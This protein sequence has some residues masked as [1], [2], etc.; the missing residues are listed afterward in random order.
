MKTVWIAC[1]L[2]VLLAACMPRQS[3]AVAGAAKPADVH[4][5]QNSL[6]W[7]GTYEG[8]LPCA[9]CP[10]V[11]TRL[12]LH[13]DGS[14]ELA[15]RALGRDEA[16]QTVLGQF[17]WNAAG[18][19]VT[20]DAKG[21]GQQVSV[22]EGRLVLLDR[23]GPPAATPSAKRVLTL[24][25]PATAAAGLAQALEAH[26]WSLEAAT[27][28]QG[29]PIAAVSPAPGRQFVFN[30]AGGRLHVE[31]GCN[32]LSGGYRIDAAG[33]MTVGRMAATMMA[34]EPLKMQ[35]D[36]ALSDLLAGPL[37]VE[38]VQGAE[39]R[40]RLTSTAKDVLILSGELTPEARYGAPSIVFLEVAARK[41]ACNNP[42]NGEALCLQ[43]RERRYDGQGLVVGAPGPW[44][45]LYEGINGFTHTPGE[46]TVLRLKQFQRS[47]ATAGAP[48]VIYVLDLKIESEIVPR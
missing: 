16:A 37:K 31:G 1:A 5:S 30:F 26:R 2:V 15:T 27:D 40:L 46:R 7:A 44:R 3:Q 6:D 13:R 42:L 39:P 23:D 43:V 38:L 33:Q 35:A 36:A 21:G 25:A 8:I 14:Y 10:G 28:G 17:A 32:Q 48:S 12:T 9:D 22:G 34:C 19:G 11:E 47:P 41:V 29:R 24:V 18:S 20:L 45:P 4:T